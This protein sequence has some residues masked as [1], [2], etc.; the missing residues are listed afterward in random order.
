[1]KYKATDYTF[2]GLFN[3]GEPFD[4]P[5]T[6]LA[7]LIGLI[8]TPTNGAADLKTAKYI[9]R[10]LFDIEE[11]VRSASEL[12]SVQEEYFPK[13]FYPQTPV[14]LTN[15]WSPISELI[16]RSYAPSTL[17]REAKRMACAVGIWEPQAIKNLELSKTSETPEALFWHTLSQVLEKA[18]DRSQLIIII[19]MP[20]WR[21]ESKYR[22]TKEP[23]S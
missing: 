9:L 3:D 21:Y 4:T 12:I 20:G 10:Y 22:Q 18:K 16:N 11:Q 7:Y 6:T 13:E 14:M 5:I 8:E 15:Q 23:D 19:A 2:W 17:K 1:M